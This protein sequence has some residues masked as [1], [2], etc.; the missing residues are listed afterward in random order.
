MAY[1]K[2]TLLAALAAIAY[3]QT[4]A[5]INELNVVLDDVKTNIAD[6]ITLS[7]T[8][9]S[10]FSLDQMPA[11]I[12]DIAA[13][14]VANPS[15]D[16]YTTLYS[17]VDFSA[18]EHMLTMVPWYSSRLLPEL[19]AMDASLTTSSS[20]ATSSSEVASSSI[21]SST[22]SSVAPS[23]SEVVSSSVAPSSSELFRCFI[24]K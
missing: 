18:V 3:A 16:S 19:E 1:S 8:P 14:L 9:N 11:G 24:L 2:I 20:A 13:Q 10:G 5:Q 15:D 6:Y 21:A 23:S 17:E 12:M 4:Q 22:S 7:Y